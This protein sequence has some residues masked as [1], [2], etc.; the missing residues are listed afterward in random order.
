MPNRAWHQSPQETA[1]G[2]LVCQV[3]CRE[4]GV[5]T[6]KATS[7]WISNLQGNS[8]RPPSRKRLRQLKTKRRFSNGALPRQEWIIAMTDRFISEN[9]IVAVFGVE[10]AAVGWN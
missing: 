5:A 8:N 1:A 7:K 3:R 10:G 6:T 9:G 2:F 4:H